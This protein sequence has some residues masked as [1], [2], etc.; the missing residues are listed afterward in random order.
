ME[1][2]RF[3][4]AVI[5]A[6]FVLVGALSVATRANAHAQLDRTSPTSGAELATAPKTAIGFT[7]AFA[8]HGSVGRWASTSIVATAVHVVAAGV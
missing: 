8:G 2:Q 3:V 1:F 5:V 6:A 4:K 7:Q